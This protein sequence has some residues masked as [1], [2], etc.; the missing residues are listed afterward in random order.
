MRSGRSS[1]PECAAAACGC[2]PRRLEEHSIKHRRT[3]KEREGKSKFG[4]NGNGSEQQPHPDPPQIRKS[5]IW[6]EGGYR[7][8]EGLFKVVVLAEEGD[9]VPEGGE[10][11][12]TVGDEEGVG[13]HGEEQ[14]LGAG[15][16]GVV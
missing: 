9:G 15:E 4:G 10:K 6:R 12:F 3:P 11:L 16:E 5:R 2:P 13:A 7:R 1:D 8:D 14:A